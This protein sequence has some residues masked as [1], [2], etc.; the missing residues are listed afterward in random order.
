MSRSY[1]N[2]LYSYRQ[3]SELR[4]KHLDLE[5]ILNYVYYSGAQYN[6]EK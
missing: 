3:G 1:A 2:D 6:P 5:N 4:F